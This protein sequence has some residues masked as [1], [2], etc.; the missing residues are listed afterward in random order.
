MH[1]VEP[2]LGKHGEKTELWQ[3]VENECKKRD[4]TLFAEFEYRNGQDRLKAYSKFV[5]SL[6]AA[7]KRD[8]GN[9]NQQPPTD[10]LSLIESL[11][12]KFKAFEDEKKK[13]K[14]KNDIKKKD[15]EVANSVRLAAL[16]CHTKTANKTA[17]EA[18]SS[19]EKNTVSKK[20]PPKTTM[21]MRNTT[22]SLF[23]MIRMTTTTATRTQRKK[24]NPP[25]LICRQEMETL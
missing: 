12:D 2:F 4:P 25:I 10:L 15:K 18:T 23:L 3:E 21:K 7:A 19:S 14:N 5:I 17:S 20:N 6:R 24:R 9:D 1:E 8:S 22:A 13:K 16:G 11:H